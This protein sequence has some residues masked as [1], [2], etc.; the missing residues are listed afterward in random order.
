MFDILG[1]QLNISTVNSTE[2]P[3]PRIVNYTRTRPQFDSGPP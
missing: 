3:H 1:L 2:A